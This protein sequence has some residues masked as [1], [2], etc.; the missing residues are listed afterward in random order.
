MV[1]AQ[2]P[3]IALITR[4]TYPSFRKVLGRYGR[5]INAGKPVGDF[6]WQDDGRAGMTTSSMDHAKRMAREFFCAGYGGLELY[7]GR[8][9]FAAHK[10]MNVGEQEYLAATDDIVGAMNKQKLDESTK[11]DVITILCPLKDDIIRV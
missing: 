11:N 1:R 4:C 8:D 3:V 6:C 10:G 7:T 9:M 2:K 5:N